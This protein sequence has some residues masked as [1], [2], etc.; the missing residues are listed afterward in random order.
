LK[1]QVEDGDTAEFVAPVIEE[2][3]IPEG[4]GLLADGAQ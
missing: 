2:L 4:S 3:P 1:V